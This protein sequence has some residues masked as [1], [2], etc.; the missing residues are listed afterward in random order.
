MLGKGNRNRREFERIV[1]PVERNAERLPPYTAEGRGESSALR[2]QETRDRELIWEELKGDGHKLRGVRE[3][4]GFSK[5]HPYV[6]SES[7]GPKRAR[8]AKKNEDPS[9]SSFIVL[10]S[11]DGATDAS[12]SVTAGRRG[13]SSRG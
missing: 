10:Q 3:F 5:K 7:A 4:S 13:A 12:G 9:G 6:G 8:Q 1:P 11:R 2:Y